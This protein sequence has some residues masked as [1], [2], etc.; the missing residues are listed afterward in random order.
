M[1]GSW[2]RRTKSNLYMTSYYLCTCSFPVGGDWVCQGVPTVAVHI[3]GKVQLTLFNRKNVISISESVFEAN[4]TQTEVVGVAVKAPSYPSGWISLSEFSVKPYSKQ[5]ILGHF[6]DNNIMTTLIKKMYQD[7]YAS[8][9][10]TKAATILVYTKTRASNNLDAFKLTRV[11]DP[12]F[13]RANRHTPPTKIDYKEFLNTPGF[14]APVGIT[15]EDFALPSQQNL[16]FISLMEQLFS[17]VGAPECPPEVVAQLGINPQKD[18]HTCRWCHE[19]V[20]VSSVNQTYC[21]KEHS[22]NFCHDVPSIGTVPGNVYIGHCS[23]NREQGGY[24]L[25]ERVLQ[26]K[27][28]VRGDPALLA[29]LVEHA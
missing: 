22:L 29:L 6:K 12:V 14:P 11:G 4:F 16:V 20:N 9:G 27:R 17:C 23:C 25:E 28:L 7:A 13:N 19:L 1:R 8:K 2:V 26:I 18:T 10:S 15:S 5:M 3:N 21:S 24:S